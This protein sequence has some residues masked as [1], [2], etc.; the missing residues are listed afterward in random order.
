VL[1]YLLFAPLL[2]PFLFS[3]LIFF[4]LRPP[5]GGIA[6]GAGGFAQDGPAL[7]VLLGNDGQQRLYGLEKLWP[8]G[9]RKGPQRCR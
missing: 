5:L 2:A 3:L 7:R 8:L 6:A 9:A 1:R 4:A